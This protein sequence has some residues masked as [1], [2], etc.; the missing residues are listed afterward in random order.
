MLSVLSR[1]ASILIIKTRY[2]FMI[3][4]KKK[5]NPKSSLN[6]FLSCVSK[7][8]PRGSKNESELSMLNESTVF[9]PL[10]FYCIMN[11]RTDNYIKIILF[12]V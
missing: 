3:K 12:P 2:I 1:I 7:E 8:I 11:F 9:E 6:I 5:K 10:G 4:K